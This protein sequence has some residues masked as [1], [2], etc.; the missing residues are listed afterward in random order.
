LAAIVAAS[1]VIAAPTMVA[2]AQ[3]TPPPTGY[4][5]PTVLTTAPGPQRLVV[6][7]DPVTALVS[8]LPPT[9]TL[10]SGA[11]YRYSIQRWME[12]NPACCHTQMNG[13]Q[14]QSWLDEGLQWSGTYIYRVTA[15]YP[16]GR[17]GSADFRHTRPDPVNPTNF[18]A[19]QTSPGTVILQWDVVPGVSWYELFGP[20]L[21]FTSFA[22]TGV[23]VFVFKGLAS[24]TYT[25]LIGSMYSSPKATG[26]VSTA[27]SAFPQVTVVVP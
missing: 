25:W 23:T 5:T 6:T 13:Y 27:A 16:D 15:F 22:V 19:T 1:S 4:R 3:L 17:V 21:P 14:G 2:Q 12:S 26:K 10:R 24:G 8:W 7:G 18:R 20:A 9:T 11:S